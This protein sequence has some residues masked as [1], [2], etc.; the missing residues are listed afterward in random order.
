MYLEHVPCLLGKSLSFAHMIYSS[1][2]HYFWQ[3]LSNSDWMES[4]WIAIFRP[5]HKCS[6]GFNSELWLSHSGT[7]QYALVHCH[8]ERWTEAP[9]L[10]DD[11]ATTVLQC[12]LESIWGPPPSVEFWLIRPDNILSCFK[13]AVVTFF[14]LFHKR[15]IDEVLLG[16]LSFW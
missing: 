15:L 2:S 5:L 11:T 3:I 16:L 12:L 1:L 10:H 4:V 7:S 9:T 14:S 6:K 8:G 13:R